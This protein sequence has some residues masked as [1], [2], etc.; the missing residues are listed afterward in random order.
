MSSSEVPLPKL[1]A[2]AQR[3]L[4]SAGITRLDQLA[5]KPEPE[6]LAL[7]GLGPA[8]LSV[9]RN[10]MAAHGF[11]MTGS[12]A[13]APTASGRNDN[14]TEPS[15]ESPIEWLASLEPERRAR[16]GRE[17]LEMFADVTG[18]PAV[19]WGPSMIGFGSHHYVYPTGREGD[20]FVTGF[21]PRKSAISLYG[22]QGHDGSDALLA[23]LGPHR[24]AVSCVYVTNLDKIDRDALR[25]LIAKAWA[26][27]QPGSYTSGHGTP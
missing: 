17:L 15:A 19:M 13:T 18:A 20:T 9:L 4:A 16:R 6:V 22:L 1:S 12:A 10:A 26:A 5:G 25:Q 23:K 21:S 14:Q 11:S 2:P 24:T 27:G 8:Q 7:H 3:A